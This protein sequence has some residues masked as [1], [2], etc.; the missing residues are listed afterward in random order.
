MKTRVLILVLSVVATFSLMAAG[1]QEASAQGDLSEFVDVNYIMMGNVPTNGQLEI[2]QAEWNQILK[3]RLNASMTISWVEW[4]DWLT[5]YNLLMATG[6]DIDLVTSGDWLDIWPNA[7]RGAFLA[8]NDL[9]PKFAPRTWAEIT[10]EQWDMCRYDGEII[11]FPEE[12]YTQWV[13]HGIYYRGDWAMEFGIPDEGS[14]LGPINN[15]EEL[16]QYFQAVK[17]NKP[18]VIPWDVNGTNPQIYNGWV[19][20]HTDALDL[21]MIPTGFNPVIWARSYD[22]RYE[23]FSPIFEDTFV[24]FARTMK[25]WGDAGYWREDVL[26]YKGDT[27]SL[28]KA[29]KSGADAHHTQTFLGLQPQMEEA[30]PGSDLKMFAWGMTREV[31]VELPIIHG[32]TVVHASSKNPA[33]AVM[34]MDEIRHNQE[35]YRLLNY[36]IEGVQYEIVN[37]MRVRPEGYNQERDG[38]YSDFWG[39]RMDKFELPSDTTY[40]KYQDIYDEY[41]RYSVPDPYG[42]FQFDMKPVQAEMAAVS[43]VTNSLGPAITYGKAGD[44]VQVVADYRDKLKKAGI[45]KILAEVNKQLAA[46]KAMME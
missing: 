42:R 18:G 33:R 36:G 25:E 3:D 27:R 1:S 39:G 40:S 12:S 6:E 45:D 35:F 37:G 19:E 41:N 43:N 30:I 34:V 7:A 32:A 20:T 13:N 14:A 46:Y 2:V 11:A 38:Y 28:L 24:E 9:I 17:D 31:L 4:A 8:L 29:G 16:E 5:K 10:P 26:N 44:P 23:A 15:Y 21:L 22:R